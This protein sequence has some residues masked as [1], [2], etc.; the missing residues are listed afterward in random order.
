MDASQI[1]MSM[2]IISDKKSP[3][4]VK[5]PRALLGVRVYELRCNKLDGSLRIKELL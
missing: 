4:A 2:R 3:G 5:Q 1:R